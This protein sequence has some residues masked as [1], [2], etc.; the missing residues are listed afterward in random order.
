[1]PEAELVR[2]GE[3]AAAIS[4][5]TTGSC[6]LVASLNSSF[7]ASALITPPPT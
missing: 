2:V 5:V 6:P 1:M 4:V 3:R 7:E